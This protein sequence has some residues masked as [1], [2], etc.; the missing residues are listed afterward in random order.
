MGWGR[1]PSTISFK[2]H[3]ADVEQI[4]R[5]MTVEAVATS[6]S[7]Y[8]GSGGAK[9]AGPRWGPARAAVDGIRAA[10]H[11]RIG[12]E[13]GVER[14]RRNARSANDGPATRA[15]D[16][17]RRGPARRGNVLATR[18]TSWCARYAGTRVKVGRA[19]TLEIRSRDLHLKTRRR[20]LAREEESSGLQASLNEPEKRPWNPCVPAAKSSLQPP[21]AG[22][23]RLICDGSVRPRIG[24]DCSGIC[25]WPVARRGTGCSIKAGPRS[26][27]CAVLSYHPGPGRRCARPPHWQR[28]AD[29]ARPVHGRR[30]VHGASRRCWVDAQ[31]AAS[32][33]A[34]ACRCPAASRDWRSAL[35]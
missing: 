15:A 12:S 3:L 11:H 35:P 14:R 5:H 13:C 10:P 33:A 19:V 9:K 26:R 16:I 34:P 6:L 23:C 4:I 28:K 20:T 21:D 27:N 17:R 30:S 22:M 32:V 8:Q 31:S 2:C 18:S 29:E 1:S 24:R 7:E 25:A